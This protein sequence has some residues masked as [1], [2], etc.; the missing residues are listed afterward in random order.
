MTPTSTE[1]MLQ[2]HFR[3]LM[4]KVRLKEDATTARVS[5]FPAD[6]CF[7]EAH[8][9]HC[10]SQ[11]ASPSMS[12]RPVREISVGILDVPAKDT[13]GG[14]RTEQQKILVMPNQ[15]FDEVNTGL[16]R[17]AMQTL[18]KL[19]E[20]SIFRPWPGPFGERGDI[21]APRDQE[22]RHID[23]PFWQ[24]HRIERLHDQ[25]PCAFEQASCGSPGC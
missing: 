13:K 23:V 18:G 16:F 11:T 14:G 22:G 24:P 2:S 19:E 25:R 17:P 20:R 21:Y 4:Q 9:L 8:L 7:S 1:D 12:L 6:S 5:P 15:K 10:R 3:V